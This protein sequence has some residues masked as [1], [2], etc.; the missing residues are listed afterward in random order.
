VLQIVLAAIALWSLPVAAVL[1]ERDRLL[2]E[3]SMGK[4]NAEATSET[5][6]GLVL[7]LRRRLS[8]AEEHERLRL[9]RELHDQTGQTLA[10]SMLEL[11]AMESCVERDICPHVCS[12]R[13]KLDEIG[14]TLHRVAWELRPTAI[15]DLG[16]ARAME[17]YV[18]N[19]SRQFGIESDFCCSDPD[20]DSLPEDVHT[21][22]F[23]VAQE[24]L[25]NVAKHARA[26]TMVSVVVER[27]EKL[28]RLI[29]EDDGCG[30]DP[31]LAAERN[32]ARTDG[33]LGLAGMR[34]RLSLVNGE[35]KI[36]SSPGA[37]TALFAS[38]HLDDQPRVS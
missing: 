28:L 8:N 20:I 1:A 32:M 23:R 12:L 10:A 13:G 22:I 2:N 17:S 26:A 5:K 6:S 24:A 36:E 21:T 15:D 35:L 37:G 16:L 27:T 34:E 38:I 9:A 4:A 30:F 7:A 33:G 14:Q 31:D 19:W 29:I 11:K 18:Q 3:L 25:T